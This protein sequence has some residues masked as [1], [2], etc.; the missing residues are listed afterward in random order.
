MRVAFL[1]TSNTISGGVFNVYRH[2]AFLH[3]RGHDVTIGFMVDQN[4]DKIRV[5]P[6]MEGVKLLPLCHLSEQGPFDAVIATW[7]KTEALIS[8][9]KSRHYFYFV[10]G[11]ED[12]FYPKGSPEATSVLDTYKKPLHYLTVSKALSERLK[13]DFEKDSQ[14]IAPGIDLA[15]F[16]DAEVAIPRRGRLRALVEGVHFEERKKVQFTL[17]V[18]ADFDDLEIVYISPSG[19]PAFDARVDYFFQAVPYLQLPS[20][21]KSCDF[22]VKL[23]STE[24]FALPVLEMFATGGTAVVTAFKGHDEYIEN[25]INAL[26]VP[27]DDKSAAKNAVAELMNNQE[28]RTDLNNNARTTADAFGLDRSGELF[29]RSLEFSIENCVGCTLV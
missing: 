4:L 13:Y 24:S 20:L 5:Y 26:V 17:D 19:K 9:I 10:Q 2:A 22:I 28:L 8:Q 27:M 29:E 21:M 1:L 7:W 11:F 18:L 6:G 16:R 25:R 3:S 12:E 23:S 14:V 15:L